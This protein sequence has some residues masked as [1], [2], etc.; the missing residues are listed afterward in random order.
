MADETFDRIRETL[1]RQRE[2]LERQMEDTDA[3]QTRT[4]DL[5]KAIEDLRERVSRTASERE[6][7]KGG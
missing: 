6:K 5:V 7:P 1:R 4:T 3:S 2:D